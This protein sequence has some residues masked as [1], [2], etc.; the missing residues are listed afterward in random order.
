MRR[1]PKVTL[2]LRVI[3][4]LQALDQR[5]P[6]LRV[7]ITHFPH[8]NNVICEDLLV[9]ALIETL[10]ARRKGRA[11]YMPRL[12]DGAELV[13]HLINHLRPPVRPPDIWNLARH[14]KARDHRSQEVALLQ[15]RER[16]ELRDLQGRTVP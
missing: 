2:R 12:Q 5:T 14:H 13:L 15:G 3:E 9:P 16:G 1:E 10:V 11:L 6:L 4:V 8:Q 7:S